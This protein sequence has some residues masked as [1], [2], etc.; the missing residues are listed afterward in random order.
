MKKKYR[1]KKYSEIDAIFKTRNGVGD[2]FFV[3]YQGES[4][5]N[6]F[7]FALTIGKKY[8]NAVKRN[9]IKRQIR[10]VIYEIHHLIKHTQFVIVIKPLASTL[11]FQEIKQKII[12][13]MKKGN[14]M[15]DE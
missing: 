2:R 5:E 3:I 14:L 1:I 11:S 15:K 6:N 4:E 13:L 10:M 8:G 12:K 9:L 7:R